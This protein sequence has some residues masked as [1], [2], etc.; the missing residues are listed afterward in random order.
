MHQ[1]YNVLLYYDSS[2]RYACP[3]YKSVY[4]FKVVKLFFFFQN[5]FTTDGQSVSQYVL[6]SD[7][8]LGP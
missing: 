8:P 7:T 5:Y 4:S 6:L 3:L 2:K 1:T